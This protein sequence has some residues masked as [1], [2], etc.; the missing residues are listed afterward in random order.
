M[1]ATGGDSGDGIGKGYSYSGPAITFG[2]VTIYDDI[3]KVDASSIKNFAS[4]VYKQ[5]ETDV[6]ANK[7]DYFT[8]TE[9]GDR[10]VIVPK[11]NTDY[12]I[13]IADG[14]EHGTL[15]GAATAKY[16]EEVMIT[17]TPALGYQ[18]QPA[19]CKGRSEQR[20]GFHGQQFLHAKEQC[21][22]KCSV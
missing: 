19:C 14:I 5:G 1:T 11:D 21:N 4:V 2:T 15:T 20:R 12:T 6:T 10:R 17:A 13:T 9:D 22:G 7:A 16:M 8:I 3:D 18:I